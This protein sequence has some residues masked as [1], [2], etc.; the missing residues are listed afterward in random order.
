LSHFSFRGG[1]PECN[2][3]KGDV[4]LPKVSRLINCPISASAY[5]QKKKDHWRFSVSNPAHNHPSSLNPSAHTANRQ[6]TDS[7]FEEMKKLG[8]AGLKPSV[9]LATL[10]KTHPDKTILATISTIYAT[11]KKANQ[12][13][14]QGISP[15]VHLNKTLQNSEFTT[16]ARTDDGG[17]LTALFFCH[18]RCVKLLSSYHYILFLDCTYKANKY[19]MPLLHIA[20]TTGSKKSFSLAFCFLH[21]ETITT[22]GRLKTSSISLHQIK[23]PFLKLSSRTENKLLSIPS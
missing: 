21:E 20:G 16:M 3:C 4:R 8:N 5:F 9:I 6:L 19:K 22:N 18:S 2:V 11:W 12:E 15:I 10:K 17:N 14:L 1:L 23:S 13:F 7:I